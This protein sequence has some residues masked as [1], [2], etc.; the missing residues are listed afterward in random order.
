MPD[1]GISERHTA[2]FIGV[3]ETR[4]LM[5]AMEGRYGELVK[6]LLAPDAAAKVAEIL[7]RLVEEDVSI[8]ICVPFSAR[9][10]SGHRKRKTVSC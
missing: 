6:E 1:T 9:W 3:Q 7:Q 8:R 2:E 10:W 5:D 4:Y